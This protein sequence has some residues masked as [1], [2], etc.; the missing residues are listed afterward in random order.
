LHQAK[1]GQ[2]PPLL[3]ATNHIGTILEL[4]QVPVHRKALHNVG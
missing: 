2:F 3:R 1:S 4:F